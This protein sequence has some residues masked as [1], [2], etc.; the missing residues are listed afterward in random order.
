MALEKTVLAIGGNTKIKTVVAAHPLGVS[1]SV[2]NLHSLT[3]SEWAAP[4]EKR[5]YYD[6]LSP[7]TCIAQV[8]RTQR[9]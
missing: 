2:P 9:N 4:K 7:G 5:G 6:D 1:S 8:S 3:S